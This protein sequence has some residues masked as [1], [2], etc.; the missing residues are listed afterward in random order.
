MAKGLV[1]FI[2]L[3]I[4]PVFISGCTPVEPKS[5]EPL[6]VGGFE[7]ES[8][9]TEPGLNEPDKITAIDVEP[10]QVEPAE[11]EPNDQ[12][13]VPGGWLTINRSGGKD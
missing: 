8:E 1:V 7:S 12:K 13:T 5:V 11:P 4:V 6:D 10:D 2:I 3:L 9:G